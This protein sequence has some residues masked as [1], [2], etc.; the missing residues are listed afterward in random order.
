M[1]HLQTTISRVID[2]ARDIPHSNLSFDI[3]RGVVF[4][5]KLNFS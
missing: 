2:I 1:I 4:N 3:L 5:I